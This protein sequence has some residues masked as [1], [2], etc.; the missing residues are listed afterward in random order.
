MSSKASSSKAS[1]SKASSSKASSSKARTSKARTS[2]ARPKKTSSSKVSQKL[3]KRKR[4]GGGGGGGAGRAANQA[5]QNAAKKKETRAVGAA[6]VAP[7]PSPVSVCD[8]AGALQRPPFP[9]PGPDAKRARPPLLPPFSPPRFQVAQSPGLTNGI[10][11][12]LQTLH[13]PATCTPKFECSKSLERIAAFNRVKQKIAA[14]AQQQDAR[15]PFSSQRGAFFEGLERATIATAVPGEDYSSDSCG[16]RC[17][18]WRRLYETSNLVAYRGHVIR[19]PLKLPLDF[20]ELFCPV[21]CGAVNLPAF[22]AATY[23]VLRYLHVLAQGRATEVIAAGYQALR[24]NGFAF[25]ALHTIE[26]GWLKARLETTIERVGSDTASMI[27]QPLNQPRVCDAFCAL[28]RR[29]N[30]LVYGCKYQ[31]V[32]FDLWTTATGSAPPSVATASIVTPSKARV[33]KTTRPLPGVVRVVI[34]PSTSTSTSA[35]ATSASA[36]SPAQLAATAEERAVYRS[37]HEKLPVLVNRGNRMFR[38]PRFA[39]LRDRT[40]GPVDERGHV[41]RESDAAWNWGASRGGGGG[42]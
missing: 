18:L 9:L 16:V 28:L 42:G 15:D 30:V 20:H 5:T 3:P 31:V 13:A 39:V 17:M 21:Q 4:G 24:L 36:S 33:L 26:D 38:L 34:E 23:I 8:S 11:D 37:L 41:L 19:W 32:P 7:S 10:D 35:S 22:V 27:A 2:K 40:D 14:V 1:S 12:W 29:H 25:A 6:G